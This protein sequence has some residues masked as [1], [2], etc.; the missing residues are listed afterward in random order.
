LAKTTVPWGNA[1]L[2]QLVR[3]SPCRINFLHLPV[4]HSELVLDK[5]VL[6]VKAFRVSLPSTSSLRPAVES[7]YFEGHRFYVLPLGKIVLELVA[8]LV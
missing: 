4:V 5:K 1:G 8:Y 7:A 3:H 6:L 2:R